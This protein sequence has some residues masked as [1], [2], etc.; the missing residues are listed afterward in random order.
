MQAAMG[1]QAKNTKR[2]TQKK[3]GMSKAGHSSFKVAEVNFAMSMRNER[4]RLCQLPQVPNLGYRW[5]RTILFLCIG[6]LIKSR[7]LLVFFSFFSLPSPGQNL[8]RGSAV[9]LA[10]L[11]PIVA[12][13][14][15]SSAM[16]ARSY[17][18]F[19]Q[20]ELL[21]KCRAGWRSRRPKLLAAGTE[22]GGDGDA[23][24]GSHR[25]VRPKYGVEGI[26]GIGLCISISICQGT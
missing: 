14:A 11:R 9:P 2:Q 5:N 26:V 16:V 4:L 6:D 24:T 19:P 13:S 23:G 10:D 12:R 25:Q 15:H 8:G 21:S 20:G 1:R 17:R 18:I 7:S 3:V 22:G